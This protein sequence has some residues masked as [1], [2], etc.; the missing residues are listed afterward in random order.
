MIKTFRSPE[1][2]YIFNSKNGMTL[3]WGRTP[4]EDFDVAPFPLI[5]DMEITEICKGPGGVPCPFCYKSNLPNKGKYTPFDKAKKIID[6]LPEK[7]TQIAFGVDA[8]CE[9][10]PDWFDIFKYAREKTFIPNV[11]VADITQE[12][13]DKISDVCGAVAVSRYANKEFCYNSLSK[14]KLKQKNIHQMISQE[15]FEQALETLE[16]IKNDDRLKDLNA[17]VFLSL[18]KKG[19]G[20]SFNRL[21]NEQFEELITKCAEL[22]ISYGFDSCSATKYLL[23]EYGQK[24]VQFVE[25]CESSLSSGYCNVDGD[26][27]PCSFTEG[28][29]N[30]KEGINIIDAESFDDVWNHPKVQIFR[31]ELLMNKRNCPIYNV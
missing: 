14:L 25:K 15:T 20:C 30:W 27:F 6:K 24:N 8:Q 3:M 22:G 17:I 26:F 9:S 21:T 29:G 28:L 16:D 31:E 12:T 18:K 11:T 4:Q 1:C 2:N 7:L 5:F 23:T 19:R 10:N 13:A